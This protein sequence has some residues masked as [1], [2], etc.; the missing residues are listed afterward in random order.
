M[1]AVANSFL[2]V[3]SPDNRLF[4]ALKNTN[5]ASLLFVFLDDCWVG[6]FQPGARTGS[7]LVEWLGAGEGLQLST[8]KS[9]PLA[10][11]GLSR[12]GIAD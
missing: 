9:S 11:A 12:K 1:A 3:L 2:I 7:A 8:K 5:L 10:Q 6:M 4:H